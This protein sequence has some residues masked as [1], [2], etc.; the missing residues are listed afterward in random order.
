M[1][2]ILLAAL[3]VTSPCIEATDAIWKN[4]KGLGTYQ[5]AWTSLNKTPDVIYYQ[6]K[7][8]N[9]FSVPSDSGTQMNT[10]LLCWSVKMDHLNQTTQTAE[11]QFYYKLSSK[12][13]SVYVLSEKV[14]SV[15]ALNYT[16]KNAI[17]YEFKQDQPKEQDPVIFTDGASCDLFNV[18]REK[19]GKGCELWVKDA[20]KD[21]VPSCCAFIFDLLCAQEGSFD[22]YKKNTCQEVVESWPRPKENEAT[23]LAQRVDPKMT[24][25]SRGD[26][27]A[28]DS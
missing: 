8:N 22:I 4:E 23:A 2:L 11:R 18:Q 19:D 7:S 21:N 17:Q 1:Y 5:R 13:N 24:N 26:L 27:T 10:N 28:E 12:Q 16:T 6:V 14:E 25:K 9:L 15:S 3:A 20:Y